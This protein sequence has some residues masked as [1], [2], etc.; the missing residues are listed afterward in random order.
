MHLVKFWFSVSRDEQRRRFLERERHPLKQWK[1]SPIDLAS[2]D[3]WD[4]YTE[5]KSAMFAATDSDFAPWTVVKSDCKKR[6]RLHA[7]R[8]VLHMMPY[9]DK[10][11]ARIGPLDPL[12]VGR[13]SDVYELGERM[14]PP[15]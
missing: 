7:I 3:R 11:V 12:L 1:L 6:A 2:L 9:A 13:A 14:S 4:D 15:A 10:D 8:Y 5:A